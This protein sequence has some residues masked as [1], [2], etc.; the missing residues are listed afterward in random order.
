MCFSKTVGFVVAQCIAHC[1]SPMVY[2]N[3]QHID[4]QSRREGLRERLS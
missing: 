3:T 4:M 1:V 2:Y